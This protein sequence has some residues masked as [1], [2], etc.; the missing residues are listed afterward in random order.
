VVRADEPNPDLIHTLDDLA[1]A[2]TRL[3]RREARPGQVQLSVRDVAARIGKAS[4]TLDPYLSG[5]R[6]CPEDVYEAILRALNVPS[7]E[8]GRW[9]NAW[10][11]VADKPGPVQRSTQETLLYRPDIDTDARIGL[12]CG[13]VRRVRSAEIWINSENTDMRMA[14][15]EENS[16]SAIIRFWGAVHD[17]TGRV[18]E[19][20]IADELERK[21]GDRRP[22][23]PGTVITTGAGELA[24][25]NG[26][27]FV[28]H[29]ASVQ[30]EPGEGYRP[31]FDLGRCVRNALVA[32]E[33]LAADHGVRTVMFPLLGAGVAG[34]KPESTARL[35]VGA[36]LDHL[37]TRPHGGLRVIY[38]LATTDGEREACEAVLAETLK[39]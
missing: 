25:H 16:M 34:G 8:L 3:R 35:M 19:D 33:R 14:R 2:F 1:Q 9:L 36:M 29:I 30:G 10:E 39:T 15:F 27:R 11:R 18:V 37:A 13:D 22:V 21:V 23:P 7:G 32:A 24:V 6:L 20:S 12:V 28:I 5:K 38:L 17:D 31:V 4:S 26:V